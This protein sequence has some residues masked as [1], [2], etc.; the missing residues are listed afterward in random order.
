M[1]GTNGI[2]P[3]K[4]TTEQLAHLR[5]L[6]TEKAEALIEEYLD[7]V[8]ARIRAKEL[9]PELR[10]EIRGHID[11][12]LTEKEDEKVP[13]IEAAIWALKQMG[14]ADEV[15]GTLGQVHRPRFNWKLLLPLTAMIGLGLLALFSLGST[16]KGSYQ[17]FNPGSR[18]LFYYVTG[19]V[20]LVAGLFFDYRLLK[21]YAIALYSAAVVLTVV[22]FS[23]DSPR[24]NGTLGWIGIGP[25]YFYWT[26]CMFVLLLLALPGLFERLSLKH[27]KWTS[28]RQ[29]GSIG[30]IVLPVMLYIYFDLLAWLLLIGYLAAALTLYARYGGS[31]VYTYGLPASFAAWM[32]VLY[33]RNEYWQAR[34]QSVF[35]PHLQTSNNNYL[36]DSIAASVRE[37]GWF[38]QGFGSSG[39]RIIYAY[40]D[41]ILPYLTYSFG[42]IAA[43]VLVACT[44]WLI[45]LLLHSTRKITDRYGR[46][47]A[48]GLS[49]LLACQWIYGIGASFNLLPFTALTMPFIGYGGSSTVIHC[50]VLGLIMGIYRRKDMIS[51]RGK[52]AQKS[53]GDR[54]IFSIGGFELYDNRERRPDWIRVKPSFKKR[55]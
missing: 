36:N 20:A 5:R 52:Q 34:I 50:A 49:V 9:H 42:W 39:S 46:S 53:D 38:G 55:S 8:C 27:E 35:A 22:F 29:I 48:I 28:L 3:E 17:Y 40:S 23:F 37:G 4:E 16:G 26:L 1:S 51:T 47:L 54:L 21:K 6:E 41:A 43:G 30:L 10:E 25:L 44:L 11:E 45:A 7:R 12:L 24:V 31:R 33:V 13:P 14:D 2:H 18:Q 32:A 19:L 15:G